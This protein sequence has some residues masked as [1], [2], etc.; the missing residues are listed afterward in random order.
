MVQLGSLILLIIALRN[1]KGSYNASPTSTANTI[2]IALRNEKG[3]YNHIRWLISPV[4]IIALR[5]EKGS[6]NNSWTVANVH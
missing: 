6:Y 5:N 1:E 4:L 2:I 3:S